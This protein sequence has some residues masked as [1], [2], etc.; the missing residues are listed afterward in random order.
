MAARENQG[1]VIGIIVL[2]ILAVMLL[3]TT[4]FST[5]K[6][7]ENYDKASVAESNSKKESARANAQ[8]AKADMLSAALGVEGT[9]PSEIKAFKDLIPGDIDG[10]SDAANSIYDIYKKDMAFNTAITDDGSEGA[11]ADLTYKGTID[12]MASALRSANE[13]ASGKSKE[14]IRIRDEAEQKISN[15]N[16]LLAE[17]NKALTAAQENLDAEKKRNKAEELALF[18]NAKSIQDASDA[19]RRE[20]DDQKDTLQQRIDKLENDMKFVI[21]T[22]TALKTRIN[23]YEK[24]VFDLPDGKIVQV[25]EAQGNVFIDIGRID[26]VR[27]NL[28]FAVYD[29]TANDFEKGS[30]KATIE[31]TEVLED[32]LSRAR[33]IYEDPLNPILTNDQVLSATFDR[34]DAVTIAL[35]GFFDLD[36][37][38]TSDLEKLKRMLVRNGARVVAWHDEEGNV[39]G[40]IDSTTRFFVLG[41][42]P[43]TGNRA[44][45]SAIASLKDQAKGN[46]VETIDLRKLLNSMGSHG[47]AEIERL[48]SGASA[49]RSRSPGGSDSKGSDTRDG[50]DSRGSDTRGSDTRGSSTRSGSGTR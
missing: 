33:I 12:K 31:I 15:I 44:V 5:M 49:F 9:T 35:G 26:G 22:N 40:S 30:H 6:A 11:D 36:R 16:G 43:R 19:Q 37:D 21:Q 18:N 47:T 1:Y 23:E 3:V 25:A 27:A 17:R 24:Q 4:V 41:R 8:K 39:T 48:N 45:I 14:T 29:R 7:Y 28:T 10:I 42:A 32:R 34:G 46:A 50:S 38:G 13:N 2:A 20:F